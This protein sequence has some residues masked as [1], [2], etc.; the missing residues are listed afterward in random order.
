MHMEKIC[1]HNSH[2]QTQWKHLHAHGENYLDFCEGVATE[3][4]PPCTWRKYC[5]IA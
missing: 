3:E 4:T 2:R 5:A 1:K